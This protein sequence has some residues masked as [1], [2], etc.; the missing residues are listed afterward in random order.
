M[1]TTPLF[2]HNTKTVNLL[3]AYRDQFD[4]IVRT[5]DNTEPVLRSGLPPSALAVLDSYPSTDSFSAL[6]NRL[7]AISPTQR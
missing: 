2:P 3:Q 4:T 7:K 6:T 1:K 5:D